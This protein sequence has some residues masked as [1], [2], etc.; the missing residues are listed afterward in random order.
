M[1]KLAAAVAA[2][3]GVSAVGI[4]TAQ[5]DEI[6]F[7]YVVASSTVTTLV[8]TINIYED[9]FEA[10]AASQLHYRYYYKNGSNAESN[11]ATC[12]EVDERLPSSP[13][14]IV[15]FDVSGHFGTDN[16]GIIFEDVAT[17]SNANYGSKTF[18]LLNI[19][20]PVRAFLVVDNNDY[21]TGAGL[22]ST[23]NSVAGEAVVL[24]FVTGAAWG[25]AAYN[26]AGIY[27]TSDDSPIAINAYDFSD[28]VETAGEVI[29]D[30]YVPVALAPFATTGG[31]WTTKFFVTPIDAATF[32]SSGNWSAPGNQLQ[33]NLSATIRLAVQDPSSATQ[34]VMFDRD[35]LPVSGQVPQV[36]TCVG[37]V[38]ATTMLSEGAL[39]RVP[40]GGW[41]N[42]V[43][44]SGVSPNPTDE[45]VVIKLEYNPSSLEV[46]TDSSTSS[47][48]GVVNNAIWLRKGIR[49][50]FPVPASSSTPRVQIY[51][52]DLDINSPAPEGV[53]Y[54]Q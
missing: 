47:V 3:M 52:A 45:A 5:A 41:S 53:T 48:D 16:L 27:G 11:S 20:L 14:D 34:D 28:A 46:D 10:P 6:L 50:S 2:T 44:S 38:E 49:E 13:N 29:A 18:S 19:T 51:A 35:E 54:A 40:D 7:P 36:V 42:L 33:S 4:G 23:A 15:T 17:S 26:A 31:E 32:D 39:N 22:F 25:Y 12:S 43:V 30:S 21:L 9:Y 8:S 1:N 37:A 24:E